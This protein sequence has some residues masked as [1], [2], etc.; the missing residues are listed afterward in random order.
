MNEQARKTVVEA[1]K[2]ASSNRRPHFAFAVSCKF[3][4]CF[5]AP[6]PLSAA[7]GEPRR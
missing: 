7:V 5:C 4:Y 6:P 1:N 3:D 2:A